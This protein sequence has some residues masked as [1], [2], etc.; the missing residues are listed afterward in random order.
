MGVVMSN[1]IKGLVDAFNVSNY[2]CDR[3]NT[4]F[5]VEG[6]K[7]VGLFAY[8]TDVARYL[9][10]V[11]EEIIKQ[12]YSSREV[13]GRH[14]NLDCFPFVLGA[15]ANKKYLDKGTVAV[16]LAD[17]TNKGVVHNLKVHLVN[18]FDRA[19]GLKVIARLVEEAGITEEEGHEWVRGT[20]KEGA[21]DGSNPL[22]KHYLYCIAFDGGYF[23]GEGYDSETFELFK[24]MYIQEFNSRLRACGLKNSDFYHYKDDMLYIKD[25]DEKVVKHVAKYVKKEAALDFRTPGKEDSKVENFKDVL[26]SL[27]SKC[28]K[29]SIDSYEYDV[30]T[31]KKEIENG[32]Y[33][34]LVPLTKVRG[35][36]LESLKPGDMYSI[37]TE[38]TN[39]VGN[40]K[41]KTE[42]SHISNCKNPVYAISNKGI[43]QLLPEIMKFPIAYNE[44]FKRFEF[45]DDLGPSPKLDS[46]SPRHVLSV[47][48]P[49]LLPQPGTEETGVAVP[50]VVDTKNNPGPSMS[51]QGSGLPLPG[52]LQSVDVMENSSE[53][54]D[55]DYYSLEERALLKF[56]DSLPLDNN[57]ESRQKIL[58][59]VFSRKGRQ[60]LYSILSSPC[61]RKGLYSDLCISEQCEK[62][63][64]LWYSLHQRER[65]PTSDKNELFY[66][67]LFFPSVSDEQ[68]RKGLYRI[69]IG[70]FIDEEGYLNVSMVIKVAKSI[71]SSVKLGSSHYCESYLVEIVEAEM[72]KLEVTPTNPQYIKPSGLVNGHGPLDVSNL[73]SSKGVIGTH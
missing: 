8:G 57:E 69:L 45:A 46:G 55:D 7:I 34:V 64:S 23:E 25:V 65:Q 61:E 31:D 28:A 6:R 41:G 50:G 12:Q 5:T 72:K 56:I 32:S 51:G 17:F 66:D 27:I 19:V 1:S 37:N 10:G 22:R 39:L 20:I 54:L 36:Q 14:Y 21:F 48:S 49:V 62:W 52:P 16:E 11:G 26:S 18:E 40:I 71:S 67:K 47:S 30:F 24:G 15:N 42:K 44:R 29:K 59:S 3:V 2:F 38:Y 58:S 4:N 13:A 60:E 63:E 43:A 70:M 73:S 68:T 35:G 9:R 33:F 53:S